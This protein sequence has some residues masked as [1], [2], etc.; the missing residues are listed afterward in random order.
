MPRMTGKFSLPLRVCDP[1]MHHGTCVMH[2]PWCMPGSLTSGFLWTQWWGKRSRHSRRRRNP[3]FNV[4]GKRPM[5][6]SFALSCYGSW[7]RLVS[8]LVFILQNRV[9]WFSGRNINRSTNYYYGWRDDYETFL[10]C[11]PCRKG[12][13]KVELGLFWLNINSLNTHGTTNNVVGSY[14]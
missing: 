1:D 7:N 6:S 3:Q 2:V 5:G 4:S 12:G 9:A 10:A 11:R 13:W 8:W 14:M